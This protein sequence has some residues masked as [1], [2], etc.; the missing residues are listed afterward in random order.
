MAKAKK[1]QTELTSD[2]TFND[3]TKD[4]AYIQ[5]YWNGHLIYDDPI[6]DNDTL[7]K[8]FTKKYRDTHFGVSGLKYI[9]RNYGHRKVYQMNIIVTE[10]HHCI[11]SITGE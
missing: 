3:L 4:L 5:V 9:Q 2:L 6:L 8:E 11:L 7:E 10:F 1:L